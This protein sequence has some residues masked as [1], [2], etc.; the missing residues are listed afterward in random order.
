MASYGFEEP[1]G[2]AVT[3]SSGTGNNGT[4]TNATRTTAGR[5]G[6]A[7]TFNGSNAWVTFR[8]RRAST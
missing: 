7:L 5:F 2:P 3:D 4:L 8:T 6:S 1:S